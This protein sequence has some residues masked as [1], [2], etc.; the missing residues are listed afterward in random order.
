V[1]D[2]KG[3][4]AVVTGSGRGFGRAIAL[5]LAQAGAA[6]VVTA[7][8]KDEI[9]ETVE[10]VTA[11]GG[12]AVAAP[13]DVNE[14]SD[15]ENLRTVAERELGAVTL[16]VHNA[17]VPWPFGPV[18]YVDPDRWWAAQAVHVRAEMYLIHTFVPSMIERGGG[19]F[20][21]ISSRG[22][23]HVGANGSGYGVSKSTQIRVAQYL[24][25]E[26]A[27]HN[28]FAF[29]VHPGNVLTGISDLSMDDPDAQR[30]RPEFVANLRQ[31]KQA[32]EDGSAGLSACAGLCVRLASGAYDGLSGRYLEPDDDLDALLAAGGQVDGA[33]LGVVSSP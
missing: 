12:R 15:I 6:V 4:V 24:A 19:R 30:Y 33:S 14:R 10:L 5:G 29:A 7:R 22:G 31:R 32:N 1:D 18:W 26:G 13:G 25:A 28:V 3:Q 16:A 27:E 23:V 20:I 8:S 11:A 21:V 17:G 2:L 9:D